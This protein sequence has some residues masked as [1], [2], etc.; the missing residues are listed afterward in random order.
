M[1]KSIVT[2]KI[3]DHCVTKYIIPKLDSLAKSCNDV[4]N[5]YMIDKLAI[6]IIDILHGNFCSELSEIFYLSKPAYYELEEIIDSASP[7]VVVYKRGLPPNYESSM[8]GKMEMFLKGKEVFK[9]N[10]K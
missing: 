10:T 8:F 4:Y 6:L 5:D 3:V 7:C 1:I 9:V 2:S